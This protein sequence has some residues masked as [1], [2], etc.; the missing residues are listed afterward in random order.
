MFVVFGG[1]GDPLGM[2]L[3]QV[4]GALLTETFYSLILGKGVYYNCNEQYG[5]A[6]TPMNH[7]F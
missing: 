4:W 1:R 5:Y 2:I 7:S 6:S 3:V